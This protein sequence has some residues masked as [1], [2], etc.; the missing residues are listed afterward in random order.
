MYSTVTRSLSTA[1]SWCGIFVVAVSILVIAPYG[2][3]LSGVGHEAF[4]SFYGI[5]MSGL[6]MVVMSYALV[7]WD[8]I[9][10]EAI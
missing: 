1:L 7:L 5:A 2:G 4:R 3:S 9:L 8:K 6:F 10:G